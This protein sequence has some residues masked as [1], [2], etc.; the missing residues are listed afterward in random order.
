MEGSP[1]SCKMIDRRGIGTFDISLLLCEN[2][3]ERMDFELHHRD[4]QAEKMKEEGWKLD[5]KE[6]LLLFFPGVPSN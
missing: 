5:R 6:A 4:Q 3:P 1:F 2:K